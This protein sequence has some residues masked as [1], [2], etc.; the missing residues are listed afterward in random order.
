M[1]GDGCHLFVIC[2]INKHP[3]KVLIDTGASRS[4][5]DIT[6]IEK[7]MQD[8]E[9]EENQQ[10][11]TGLGSNTVQ[12]YFCNFDSFEIGDL[13]LYNYQAVLLDMSHVNSSYKSLGI[14]TIVG[15]IGGDILSAYNAI[16]DYKKKEITFKNIKKSIIS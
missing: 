3:F 4:A 11:T 13:Q 7:C 16:I 8:V 5:F 2:K 9:H 12:S 1:Q 10:M 14:D 15:V 6:E